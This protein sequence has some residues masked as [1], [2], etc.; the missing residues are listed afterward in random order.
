MA[1]RRRKQRF[2]SY[3]LETQSVILAF[4]HQPT[5]ERYLAIWQYYGLLAYNLGF[6]FEDVV[7]AY[8]EKIKK[9]II[10]A[11]QVIKLRNTPIFRRLS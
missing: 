10:G 6:T 5:E 3:F 8:L 1:F 7:G 4:I 9:I 11:V 2:N